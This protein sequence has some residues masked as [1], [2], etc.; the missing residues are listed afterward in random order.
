MFKNRKQYYSSSSGSNYNALIDGDLVGRTGG[1]IPM[2]VGLVMGNCGESLSC[3]SNGMKR[4][5]G[6]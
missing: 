3:N 2:G 1:S 5:W 6:I 4:F